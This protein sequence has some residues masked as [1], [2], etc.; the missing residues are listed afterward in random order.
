[1]RLPGCAHRKS[2]SAAEAFFWPIPSRYVKA[3]AEE[4]RQ[5]SVRISHEA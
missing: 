4:P 3:V 2:I 1:V 5:A